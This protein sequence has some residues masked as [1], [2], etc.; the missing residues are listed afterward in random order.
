MGILRSWSNTEIDKSLTL[1][2]IDMNYLNI[3][4]NNSNLSV[5][6]SILSGRNE[7]IMAKTFE[8]LNHVMPIVKI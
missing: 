8:N 4:K 1:D 2:L 5:L 6:I 3:V 7:K